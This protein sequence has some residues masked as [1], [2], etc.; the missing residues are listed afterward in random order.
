MHKKL[1]VLIGPPACGGS[2]LL[3]EMGR[4]MNG[5]SLVFGT[6]NRF[7]EIEKDPNHRHH[8]DVVGFMPHGFLVPDAATINVFTELWEGKKKAL[9]EVAHVWL[10]KV[11]RTAYQANVVI[12]YIRENWSPDEV[13]V[14]HIE[15][16]REVCEER[17]FK[18]RVSEGRGDDNY[19]SVDTRFYEWDLNRD[20]LLEA[21]GK[22]ARVIKFQAFEM[23]DKDAPLILDSLGIKEN[24]SEHGG[25]HVGIIP[26]DQELR[27]FQKLQRDPFPASSAPVV[28]AS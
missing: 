22:L 17:I 6:G 18:D 1:F 25:N 10:D 12:P 24:I 26:K 23:R 11:I 5:S 8:S 14:V 19:D 3:A 27:H 7:R 20:A 13:C 16:P 21:L 4:R 9:G 2:A 15:T 28:P